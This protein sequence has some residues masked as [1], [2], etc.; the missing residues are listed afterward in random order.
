MPRP[1]RG[2][3]THDGSMVPG[4]T[5]VAGRF[6][7]KSALIG[8]AG[9]VGYEQGLAGEPLDIYRSRDDAGDVGTYTHNIWESHLWGRLLPPAPDRFNDEMKAQSQ[10]A[11]RSARDWLADTRLQ[12]CPWEI[13][14]VSERYRLGGTPDGVS[15]GSRGLGVV[16]WKTNKSGI[17]VETLIQLWFYVELIEETCHVEVTDGIHIVRFGKLG[18]D[19]AHYYFP[20]DSPTRDLA[21]G[22]LARYRDAYDDDIKLRKMVG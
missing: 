14:L 3:R 8:W 7:D 20:A 9:R 2:Y 1:K 21:L 19:F 22:Q 18:A 5:T 17:Y 10:R 4:V 11:Y 13:P 16:D 12:I 15:R 6:G